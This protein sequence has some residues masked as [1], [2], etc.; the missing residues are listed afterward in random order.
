MEHSILS[1][2]VSVNFQ[3]RSINHSKLFHVVIGMSVRCILA[4]I[5]CVCSGVDS[6]LL[7]SFQFAPTLDE[8]VQIL[9]MSTRVKQPKPIIW[10]L[11]SDIIDRRDDLWLD[12]LVIVDIISLALDDLNQTDHIERR[13]VFH[14]LGCYGHWVPWGYML[15]IEMFHSWLLVRSSRD[16]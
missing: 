4:C 3:G 15:P 5:V 6:Y 1:A 9:F 7:R 16:V 2:V 11:G 13:A 8:I 10:P 12:H 14:E